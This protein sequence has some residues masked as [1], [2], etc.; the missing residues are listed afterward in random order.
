MSAQVTVVD[1][2]GV[3]HSGGVG[4]V[5]GEGVVHIPSDSTALLRSIDLVPNDLYEIAYQ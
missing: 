4:H 3:V 5:T 2:S 1:G